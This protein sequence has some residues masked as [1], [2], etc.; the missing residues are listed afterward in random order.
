MIQSRTDPAFPTP[1]PDTL[2]EMEYIFI[3]NFPAVIDF[4]QKVFTSE[5]IHGLKNTEQTKNL[6]E[7]RK[8]DMK[9]LYG[10]YCSNWTKT[11]HILKRFKSY[12]KAMER[13]ADKDLCLESD[14]I[15]P[16]QMLNRYHLFFRDLVSVCERSEDDEDILLYKEC[17]KI[18]QEISMNANDVMATSRIKNFPESEDLSR[19][20]VLIKRGPVLCKI[21]RRSSCINLLDLKKKKRTKNTQIQIFFFKQKLVFCHFKKRPEEFGLG[22][23][24][25]YWTMIPVNKM[26]LDDVDDENEFVLRNDEGPENIRVVTTSSE[27]KD[28][29]VRIIKEEMEGFRVR[30]ESMVKPPK[31][32]DEGIVQLDSS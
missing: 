14:L 18:C 27:E 26:S 16:I 3:E 10:K 5:L 29:W 25:R 4:H 11:E 9:D 7:K 13:H 21:Q 8:Y 6:L 12:F 17:Q 19:M 30:I 23:E 32:I 20:G 31:S 22:D 28:L 2:Q 24:Y 15:K 1:M